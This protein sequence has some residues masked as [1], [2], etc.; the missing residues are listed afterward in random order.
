MSGRSSVR[1]TCVVS[2]TNGQGGACFPALNPL[3][4]SGRIGVLWV[5]DD[6]RYLIPFDAH[7]P[8]RQACIDSW[9]PIGS[10]GSAEMEIEAIIYYKTGTNV[11]RS[12][13]DSWKAT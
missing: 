10:V 12:A 5:E 7:P 8:R 11:T 2:H 4:A 13:G 9:L 3:P 6:R 1:A